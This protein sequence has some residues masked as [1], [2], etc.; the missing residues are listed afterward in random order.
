MR[1]MK[2]RFEVMLG[3]DD[4][5]QKIGSTVVCL[6]RKQMA[7]RLYARLTEVWKSVWRG[8]SI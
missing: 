7:H 3:D 1:N 4:L 8:D 6:W 2:I 5:Q